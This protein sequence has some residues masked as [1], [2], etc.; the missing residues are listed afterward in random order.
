MKNNRGLGKGLSALFAETEEDYGKSL[1]FDEPAP[2]EEEKGKGGVTEV[3][4]D[5]VYPNPDQPRKAFD[6]GALEE[7]A[8]SIRRHGVIMPLIVNKEPKGYMIIAGERRYRAEQ[9]RGHQNRARYRKELHRAARSRKFPL[10]K[11]C[12]GR[13]STPSRPPRRCAPSW[14]ITE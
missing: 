4:I 8:Q 11:T 9:A 1:L 2:K 12:R 14:K 3:D 13:I 6:E 5:S 10:S 7:L